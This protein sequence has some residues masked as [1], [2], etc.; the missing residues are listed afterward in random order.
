M[1]AEALQDSAALR[2]AG[3]V[4]QAVQQ[5][6]AAQA[7]LPTLPSLQQEALDC[8][9]QGLLC[10]FAGDNVTEAVVSRRVWAALAHINAMQARV[11]VGLSWCTQNFAALAQQAALLQTAAQARLISTEGSSGDAA[12]AAPPQQP[13]FEPA[14]LVL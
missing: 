7:A 8:L 1:L 6:E 13:H 10:L 11:E 12:V 5:M 3:H 2:A 14:P 9:A 4:Q